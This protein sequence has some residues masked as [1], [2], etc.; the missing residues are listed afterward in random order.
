M[1]R[2]LLVLSLAGLTVLASASDAFA[3]RGGYGRGYGGGYGSGWY[4]RG[5]GYG[6]Y[7]YGGYGYGPRW[8]YSPGISISVGRGGYYSPYGYYGGLGY[9]S[10][11]RGYGYSYAPNYYVPTPSYLEPAI[12]LPTAQVRPSYYVAPAVPQ[13][14][15]LTVLVPADDAQVWF[16][17][18]ATT[19]IGME[20][21]FESPP[22]EPNQNF[23]YTLKARW[24]ENGQAFNQERRVTIQA[25]QNVTV[26]FRA[27]TGENLPPPLLRLPNAIPQD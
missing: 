27:N 13:S 19:Q 22:L 24:M 2:M 16:E 8:G 7:R 20:R 3:Q 25:G 10:Y 6:G 15:R 23:T 14:A 12:V 5:Y 11:Y 4:G 1:R 21:L 17:N 18:R 26:N 9:S